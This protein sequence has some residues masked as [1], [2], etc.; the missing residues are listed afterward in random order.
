MVSESVD[1]IPRTSA[2]PC[3]STK[4]RRRCLLR[5][6]SKPTTYRTSLCSYDRRKRNFSRVE[7]GAIRSE[8]RDRAH[9]RRLVDDPLP[10]VQNSCQLWPSSTWRRR[11]RTRGPTCRKRCYLWTRPW[12]W[13][14]TSFLS[15]YDFMLLVWPS[16]RSCFPVCVVIF[17]SLHLGE[18][19]H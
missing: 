1:A 13:T 18:V 3:T 8:F 12:V 15:V 11:I 6:R 14:P 4:G 5:H 10:C 19:G 2:R 7:D 9:A 17:F 16:F